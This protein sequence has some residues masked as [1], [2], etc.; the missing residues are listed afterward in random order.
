MGR[1]N[2]V[3]LLVLIDCYEEMTVAEVDFDS[4]RREAE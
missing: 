3:Q 2:Q 4:D 1:L